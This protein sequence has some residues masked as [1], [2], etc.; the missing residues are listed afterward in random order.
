MAKMLRSTPNPW[1]TYTDTCRCKQCRG[2]GN[3][4]DKVRRQQRAREKRF[5]RREA[6]QEQVA[7]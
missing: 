6:Q 5:W 2:R 4:D 1:S 7:S 3:A